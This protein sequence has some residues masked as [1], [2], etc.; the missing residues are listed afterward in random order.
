MKI[1]IKN[2]ITSALFGV[3]VLGAVALQSFDK[4]Q[5]ENTWYFNSNDAN[6][7]D[8]PAAWTQ[9]NPAIPG[10]SPLATELPCELK[11][12]DHVDD[13][14]ELQAYFD[15]MFENKSEI[16]AAASSRRNVTP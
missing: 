15:E 2:L 9:S 3:A 12:P 13:Q 1:Q 4:L 16:T 14:V 5:A 11:T 6:E 8:N 10:C 7:I